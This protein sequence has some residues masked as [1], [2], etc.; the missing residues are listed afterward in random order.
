MAAA[1]TTPRAVS[2]APDDAWVLLISTV[3]YAMGRACTA[4][5][6]AQRLVETYRAAL[7]PWRVAQIVREVREECRRAEREGRPLGQPIDHC[8]WLDFADRLEGSV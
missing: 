8:G 4:P 5:T 1:P 7:A 6:A 3:R 2:V